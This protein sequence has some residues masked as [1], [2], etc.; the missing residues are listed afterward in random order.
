[1]VAKGVSV[2][3]SGLL[4]S[5]RGCSRSRLAGREEKIRCRTPRNKDIRFVRVDSLSSFGSTSGPVKSMA[6]S[7]CP[8]HENNVILSTMMKTERYATTRS[9]SVDLLKGGVLVR[10]K[11]MAV[12]GWVGVRR[13]RR[14]KI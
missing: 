5:S 12:A 8:P 10:L 4:F 7:L 11:R 6:T 14:A 1:M 13:G 9:G 2:S 3:F